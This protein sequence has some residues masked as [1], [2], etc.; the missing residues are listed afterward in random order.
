MAP[1]KDSMHPDRGMLVS[2]LLILVGIVVLL[3][4]M[5]FLSYTWIAYWP[6]LLIV[7]GLAKI[8]YDK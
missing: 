4:N 1:K 8:L 2:L 5:G 7:L 3:V 6:V